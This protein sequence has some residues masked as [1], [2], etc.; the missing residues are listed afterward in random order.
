MD[1]NRVEKGFSLLAPF[2]D[3]LADIVFGK[4]IIESQSSFFSTISPN[5]RVLILAGGTGR[6]LRR[7]DK[8]GIPITVDFVDT[9]DGMLKR[10]MNRNFKNLNA[11][12][13][14]KVPTHEKIYDVVII[15]FFF[16][17]LSREEVMGE[18]EKLKILTKDDG[19]ILF[20]DFQVAKEYPSRIWQ[21]LLL[22]LM[23]GFFKVVVGI[24]TQRLLKFQDLFR[25]QN[26]RMC[27]TRP[28]FGKFITSTLY[29]INSSPGS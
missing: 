2:Y 1:I 24:K 20:T 23:Y 16:D 22:F 6:I 3:L 14:K 18:L 10:A 8:C 25:L 13:G 17:M 27:E 29:T 12:F 28:Y 15:A 11:T 9:S 21:R 7:L 26:F 5:S 4:A 19:K